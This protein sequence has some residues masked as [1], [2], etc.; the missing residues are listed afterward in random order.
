VSSPSA[1]SMVHYAQ[2]AVTSALVLVFF[3]SLGA[4]AEAQD[5]V[6]VGSALISPGGTQSFPVHLLNGGAASSIAG[7][8]LDI[9]YDSANTPIAAKGDGTPD[10]TVN[11]AISKNATAFAFL[12]KGCSGATCNRVRAVVLDFGNVAPIPMDTLLFSCKVTVP[13]GTE[14]GNYLLPITE[15][16]A[17]SP[18]GQLVPIAMSDG[19]I[20]V[21]IPSGGGC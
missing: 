5:I 18:S 1:Q 12:P 3:L 20:S 17:S 16:Y 13:T 15:A 6:D 14:A 9:T 4:P 10:C 19:F 11:S 2:R 21:P 8:Q 7:V